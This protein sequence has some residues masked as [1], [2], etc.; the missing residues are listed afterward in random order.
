MV[1]IYV[2]YLS[3]HC[4]G[5]NFGLQLAGSMEANRAIGILLST[6]FVLA[7]YG[8]VRPAVGRVRCMQYK[9][10]IMVSSFSFTLR[11]ELA[12]FHSIGF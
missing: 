12:R 4:T 8:Y 6:I 7:T 11:Y 10:K 1:R 3:I 2:G 5:H 9:K